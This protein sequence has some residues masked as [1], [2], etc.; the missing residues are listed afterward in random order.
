MNW[1]VGATSA[2]I[3]LIAAGT[4]GSG[5]PPAAAAA[6]PPLFDAAQA[7]VL[8]HKSADSGISVVRMPP[9]PPGSGPSTQPSSSETIRVPTDPPSQGQS[10]GRLIK[11]TARMGSQSG[12]PLKGWLGVNMESVELPLALSLGLA[13]AEGSLILNTLSGGPASQAGLRFGD[14]VVGMNGRSS[15]T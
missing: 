12:D 5:L 13:N 8:L 15:P 11:L 6:R 9:R 14:I 1:R 10:K 4:I 2:C 3:T 7:D